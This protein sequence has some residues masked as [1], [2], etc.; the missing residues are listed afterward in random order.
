MDTRE[1]SLLCGSRLQP[2]HKAADSEPALARVSGVR[3]PVPTGSRETPPE[4]SKRTAGAFRLRGL[5]GRTSPTRL[6]LPLVC[7]LIS[8]A[9]SASAP[10]TPAAATPPQS[11]PLEF[12]GQWGAHGEGPGEMAQPIGLAV[13]LN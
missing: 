2:R 11:S 1:R 13:D 12:I 5:L 10:A 3:C 4:S 6:C 8:L 9:A 7:V